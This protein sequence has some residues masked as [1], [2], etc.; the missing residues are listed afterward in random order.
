VVDKDGH[1]LSAGRNEVI[2][3]NDEHKHA[4]IRY[5]FMICF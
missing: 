3:R 1:I 4:E 5:D 2:A